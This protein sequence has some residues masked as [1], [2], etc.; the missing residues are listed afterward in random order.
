MPYIRLLDNND[1]TASN[2][3]ISQTPSGLVGSKAQA[4]NF[5]T[6][7]LARSYMRGAYP[8][9]L[10]NS[11]WFQSVPYVLEDLAGPKKTLPGTIL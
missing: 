7:A 2:K 4:T 1:N 6:D 5:S 11:G 8:P 10:V 3:Y 9:V